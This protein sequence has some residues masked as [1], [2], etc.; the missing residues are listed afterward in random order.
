M[1]L[2]NFSS[3]GKKKETKVNNNTGVMVYTRVSSKDQESNK[4]LAVQLE[5]ARK[6][7][8]QNN[9]EVIA[10]FGGTY[11]SASGDFTRREFMRLISEIRAMK[12]KPLAILLNTINRFSRSGGSA[13]GLATE[14]VEELGVHI[15]DISTGKNTMTEEGKLEIYQGLLKA[16]QENLDKM[17]H[18]LPGMETH[19]RDGNWLGVAPRGYDQFGPKVKDM[20]FYNPV[21]KIVVNNEGELLK[22]AWEW[23]LQGDKDYLIIPKLKDLGLDISKQAISDMW[24]NPFYAGLISHRLLDGDVVKGNWEPLVNPND[25]MMVQQILKVNNTGYKQD[26]SN[27]NRPL[28]GFVRCACCGNKLT[29][30]EVKA[31]GLHYY[32][33]QSCVKATI[34]VNTTIKSKD[35]GA[36]DLFKGLLSSLEPSERVLDL[37]KRQLRHSYETLS[38]ETKSDDEVFR[39]KLIKLE[40]ELKELKVRNVKGLIDD[41]DIYYE[42]KS[43]LEVKIDELKQKLIQTDSK[44]SNLDK[45]IEM[46]VDVVSKISKYWGCNDIHIKKRVQELVFPEGL[47]LD[48]KNRRYLTKKT[49]SVFQISSAISRVSEGKNE[50][51]SEENSEPSLLVAGARLE[52]T[53]FGL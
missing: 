18:T 49:N 28:M 15:I 35:V 34:N 20:R 43:E 1:D 13:V 25:Y 31:K 21:Q 52:R 10:E 38:G 50:N 26:K 46:S 41:M 5:H 17:K 53:T 36:D 4:S 51:G 12:Q 9:Y 3:L 29:G 37:F 24:R 32:N 40:A 42:V 11:E 27:P 7:A 6:Y 39:K 14:L 47:S 33:C 22:K 2:S 48:I 45:Y 16:R 44:I 23:K 30:Y 8:K 19:L